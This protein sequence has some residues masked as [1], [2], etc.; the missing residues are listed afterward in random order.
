MPSSIVH[1][2]VQQRLSRPLLKEKPDL[3]DL[4]RSEPCNPYA[5]FGSIGPD[6]L[7]FSLKEYGT[8]LDELVNFIFGVYDAL[9][10]I[11]DFYETTIEPVVDDIEDAVA[12]V[13]EALFQG[14]FTQ[15][16]ATAGLA[17]D[18]LLNAA[19]KVATDNIDFFYPFYPKVQQGAPEDEWYWFDFLHYRRTGQFLS[20]MWALAEGDKD[21]M[22]YCL[23]Y[24]SHIGTD[25]VGHPFV[26]AIT[27]G[28]FR[29]HWHRHKLVENWIDA[30]ARRFYTDSSSLKKCLN[31]TADDKYVANAISG[32]YYYRLVEFPDGKLPDKL[33]DLLVK[34]MEKTYGDIKHPTWMNGADL[35]STYRLWLKWFERSTTISDAQKPTPVPPPG[36]ATINLVNDYTSGFP[37][38]PSGGGGGGGFSIGAIFAAIFAFAK[39]LADVISYTITWIITHAHEIISLPFVEAIGLLKWLIYQIQKGLW[40]IYDNLRFMLVLGGYLFPEPRDLDKMPWGKALLNTSFAHMTGGG[41]ANFSQYPRKQ[42]SH[43]LFGP[44]NHHLIYPVTAQ[45]QQ[46]AEPAPIPF[47]G[48]FPETFIS[49][50]FP[51]NPVV[52]LLHD[53]VEAYGPGMTFTHTVDQETWHTGQ[54]GSAINFCVRL[55]SERMDKMP[56][57]NLD[58]DRGYGWKTW[59]ALND[60]ETSN[61]VK[62]EYV[63]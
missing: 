29:T 21:L 23:G 38:P 3:A 34:A 14:L 20:N 15:I 19:A 52:E 5:A 24:A 10:P 4:L 25:V 27:G 40:E 2:I 39:W 47:H 61:P 18:T 55:I 54:F 63:T 53:C 41:F 48:V 57:F 42:E 30:Y 62:T 22:R 6:F 7:F 58:G 16:K 45:E 36:S 8:P 11:R 59:K 46:H 1:L 33:Q 17:A 13:D 32:S 31:L 44:T 60:L 51:I 28:P 50:S 35:D 56:D 37:S 49:G 9:E 43:G 12:A 26:N